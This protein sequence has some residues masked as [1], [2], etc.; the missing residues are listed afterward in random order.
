MAPKQKKQKGYFGVWSELRFKKWI[1]DIPI[2][3]VQSWDRDNSDFSLNDAHN[4][5]YAR[6]DSLPESIKNQL[7]ERLN[8]SKNLALLIG[9]ETKKTKRV[10]WSMV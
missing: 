7:I 6:D 5:N 1:A 2:R 9:S 3:T 4:V 10:F 8:L